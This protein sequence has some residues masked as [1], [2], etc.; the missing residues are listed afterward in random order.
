MFGVNTQRSRVEHK[1]REARFFYDRLVAKEGRYAKLVK[2]KTWSR[3]TDEMNEWMFFASA[4]ISATR[5][6]YLHLS[7][8]TKA[9]DEN[10]RWLAAQENLPVHEI[11]RELRDFMLHEA[12]PNAGYQADLPPQKAGETRGDWVVRGMFDELRNPTIQVSVEE[13]LPS[14]SEGAKQLARSHKKITDLFG[15]ILTAMGQLVSEAQARNMLSEE[16]IG[17]GVSTKR[18]R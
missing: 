3:A 5:S 9:H 2:Q 1:L 11:G 16:S 18:K 6:T 15:T 4:F 8:A 13:A 14:L 10:K 7:R 17:P 12:T